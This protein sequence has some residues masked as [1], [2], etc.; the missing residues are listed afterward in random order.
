MHTYTHTP[1]GKHK[2]IYQ[3]EGEERDLY[4]PNW[5]RR[6]T[7][8]FRRELTHCAHTCMCAH[9]PTGTHRGSH[10]DA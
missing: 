1:L 4:I 2:Y 7:E 10:I 6:T 3:S 8:K 5:E 9:T